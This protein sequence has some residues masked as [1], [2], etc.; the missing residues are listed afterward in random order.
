ML[1]PRP[2]ST[3]KDSQRLAGGTGCVHP[4][5]SCELHRRS[6]AQVAAQYVMSPPIRNEEHQ[7]KLRH[8]L[9]GG[10]LQIVATDHCAFNSSQKAAG[11]RDFRKIPNGVNGIEASCP[12]SN[13]CCLPLGAPAM[14]LCHVRAVKIAT[15]GTASQLALT[16]SG[17]AGSEA[18]SGTS[19]RFRIGYSL[20]ALAVDNL[21]FAG[22]DACYMG[23]P[24]QLR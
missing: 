22:A 3:T 9:A 2:F 1:P 7:R 5:Q 8:A 24:G 16:K 6:S 11:L 13:C 20:P 19:R 18:E 14:I 12:P 21:C 10:A 15:T 17:T 23:H 4:D